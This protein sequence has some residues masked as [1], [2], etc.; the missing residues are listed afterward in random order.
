MNWG[1][2]Q[3]ESLY[4]THHH[5]TCPFLTEDGINLEAFFNYHV[6]PKLSSYLQND[7]TLKPLKVI[8]TEKAKRETSILKNFL[9]F[10][11]NNWELM[12]GNFIT[13]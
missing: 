7:G 8:A 9:G 1:G 2:G 12:S 5:P 10:E 3:G 11:V 4:D 13:D 6:E